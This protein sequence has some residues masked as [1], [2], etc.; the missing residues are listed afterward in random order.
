MNLYYIY[1]F[2][3]KCLLVTSSSKILFEKKL[4]IIICEIFNKTLPILFNF[5]KIIF[6]S[7]QKMIFGKFKQIKYLIKKMDFQKNFMNKFRK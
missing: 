5:K 1:R 6:F 7:N 4:T 3:S 2:I